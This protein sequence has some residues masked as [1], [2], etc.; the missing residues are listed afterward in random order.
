MRSV[1]GKLLRGEAGQ[2]ST[3]YAVIVAFS[4]LVA[5]AAI[6]LFTGSLAHFHTNVSR[7]VCLPVP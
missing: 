5:L 6:Y 1:I 3:E 2:S 7:V 4:V